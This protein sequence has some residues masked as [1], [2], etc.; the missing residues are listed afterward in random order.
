MFSKHGE[1][2][3]R[4]FTYV[5]AIAFAS[6]IGS[7]ASATPIT[8]DESNL[9]SGDFSGSGSPTNFNIGTLGIGDNTVI[10]ELSGNCVQRDCNGAI[11]EDSQDSFNFTIGPGTQL[12]SAFGGTEGGGPDGLTITFALAE[13]GPVSTIAFQSVPINSGGTIFSGILGPGTYGV[14][15]FGQSADDEGMYSASWSM[16]FEVEETDLAPVP[17]PAGM[18]LLLG[19]LGGLTL[20]RLKKRTV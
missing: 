13:F 19:G 11:D 4:S 3:V 20:L 14:S 10:G 9:S 2:K 15:A 1:I 17:L 8:F 18:A 5:Y 7:M 12:V 16:S 6:A